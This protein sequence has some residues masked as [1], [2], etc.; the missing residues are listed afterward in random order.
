VTSAIAWTNVFPEAQFATVL[1]YVVDTWEELKH[2]YPRAHM[3]EIREEKLT[4]SL[5]DHLDDPVRRQRSGI[6]GRFVCER[7]NF[8]RMPNGTVKRESRSDIVY[9]DAVPGSPQMVMEFK[10]LAG[11]ARLHK[12][13]CVEGMLRFVR[14]TYCPEQK[15]GAMCGILKP[16]CA[17]PSA[18]VAYLSRLPRDVESD[19][20]CA[21]KGYGVKMPSKLAPSVATCD[22][23]HTRGANC[24]NEDLTLAHVFVTAAEDA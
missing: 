15:L 7:W 24:G 14:G 20:G 16:H 4:D 5:T 13:Y 19:L 11:I 8:K 9:V 1:R 17:D 3:Y 22:S 21:A 12:S 10:K 6:P 18:L 2:T 23:L